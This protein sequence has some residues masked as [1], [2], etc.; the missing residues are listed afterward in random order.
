[1]ATSPNYSD[2]RTSCVLVITNEKINYININA[3]KQSMSKV[4]Q[5]LENCITGIEIFTRPAPIITRQFC[6]T[7]GILVP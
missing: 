7:S 5:R 6:R 4:E 1:M 2:N 3:T